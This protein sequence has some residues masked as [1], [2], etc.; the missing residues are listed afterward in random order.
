LTWLIFLFIFSNISKPNI[1]YHECAFEL[2]SETCKCQSS[3]QPR[4]A[5]DKIVARYEICRILCGMINK[6][7]SND[8]LNNHLI[9]LLQKLMIKRKETNFQEFNESNLLEDLVEELSIVSI[10]E[11][12]IKEKLLEI[13][14][15]IFKNDDDGKYLVIH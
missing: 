6:N 7:I 1:A 2:E 15:K 14:E 5:N 10:S 3:N 4:T 13:V 11:M 12:A 8:P 9:N